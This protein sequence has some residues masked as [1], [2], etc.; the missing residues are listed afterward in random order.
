M[1]FLI[2]LLLSVNVGEITTLEV[3]LTSIK[4]YDRSIPKF[5]FMLKNKDSKG[6][7]QMISGIET[8]IL[9]ENEFFEVVYINGLL[10]A[11][12]SIHNHGQ[13]PPF[14][15]DGV[16]FISNDPILPGE[17]LYFKYLPSGGT[18]WLHSHYGIQE[19]QGKTFFLNFRK[20]FI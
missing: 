18:Y 15:F 13:T 20:S 2:F 8:L 11:N 9:E 3:I 5:G 6:S 7:F 12:T 19:D 17:S 1:F 10:E 14:R 16:P 4:F